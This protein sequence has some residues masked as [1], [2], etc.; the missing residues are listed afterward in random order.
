MFNAL[1]AESGLKLTPKTTRLADAENA[2][3][4][5]GVNIRE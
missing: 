2:I 1:I 3:R 5:I 4:N